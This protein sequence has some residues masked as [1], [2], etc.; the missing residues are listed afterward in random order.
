MRE[1]EDCQTDADDDID[2]DV[3]GA[4]SVAGEELFQLL[5]VRGQPAHGILR[6]EQT[7]AE[8]QGCVWSG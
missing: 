4:R 8:T 1:Q 6:V 3:D 7:Q 5:P 2:G